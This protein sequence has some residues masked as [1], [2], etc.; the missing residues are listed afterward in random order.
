MTDVSTTSQQSEALTSVKSIKTNSEICQS[1]VNGNSKSMSMPVSNTSSSNSTSTS[2]HKSKTLTNGSAGRITGIATAIHSPTGNPLQLTG[3]DNKANSSEEKKQEYSHN[4]RHTTSTS[5]VT[6][7]NAGLKSFTSSTQ[8]SSPQISPTSSNAM[9]N[10]KSR[11]PG[12][13]P[14]SRQGATNQVIATPASASVSLT[15]FQMS[16]DSCTVTDPITVSASSTTIIS[17]CSGGTSSSS[18]LNPLQNPLACGKQMQREVTSQDVDD[19]AR[20][21][22]EKPEAFEKWL[23]ERAPPE[24]L[25]RLHD[26]IEGRKH[27]PKRPSVTSDLFQQWMAASP[28]QVSA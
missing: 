2:I 1:T 19:V 24:A 28:I 7:S 16:Q 27:P 14:E 5:P 17:S 6:M 3:L 10:Q 15:Q 4:K 22:E 12:S 9:S 23:M 25:M 21:F 8:T 13:S 20:L 11:L 18:S 26:F